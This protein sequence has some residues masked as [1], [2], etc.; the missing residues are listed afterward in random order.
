[1]SMVDITATSNPN[2]TP[3]EFHILLALAEEARHGYGIKLD[4]DRR[5]E[6]RIT[7]GSGT[8]YVAIQRLE[9]E[10]LVMG[11][12]RKATSGREKL[13][14]RYFALTD[15]G[16]QTLRRELKQLDRVVRYARTLDLLGDAK[17]V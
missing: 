7:L 9:K 3:V 5:T 11:S 4:V 10:G 2:L 6:G 15:D 14:R 13:R 17:P 12:R 1:M 16:R 8:L